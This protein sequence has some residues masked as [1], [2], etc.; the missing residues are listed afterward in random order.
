MTAIVKE[1]YNVLIDDKQTPTNAFFRLI[2]NGWKLSL[3]DQCK[4]FF[5][6]ADK[7]ATTLPETMLMLRSL[8]PAIE[9]LV[10][11]LRVDAKKPKEEQW[12]CVEEPD[13][14]SIAEVLETDAAQFH[15]RLFLTDKKLLRIQGQF[16]NIPK[17]GGRV[18][19]MKG[20]DGNFK[21]F[22]L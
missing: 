11:R 10:E 6:I 8:K 20:D 14:R 22:G 21:P 5:N 13:A 2:L 3:D 17:S 12:F 15:I 16:V 18:V 4:H 7:T 1:G 9:K 19:L